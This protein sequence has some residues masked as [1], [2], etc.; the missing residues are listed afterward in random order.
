M[1]M[2]RAKLIRKNSFTDGGGISSLLVPV[3]L[4]GTGAALVTGA[5]TAF[6]L[7]KTAQQ[8]FNKAKTGY[9]T[10][11]NG[12]VRMTGSFNSGAVETMKRASG[13]NYRIFSEMAENVLTGDR[14]FDK[15]E[16][17]GATPELISALYNM[18]GR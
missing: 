14:A 8:G 1:A 2:K 11:S 4:T 3:Q 6:S 10:Y 13:G 12:P 17:Y 5:T 18:G 15:L 9:V 16:T 7:A